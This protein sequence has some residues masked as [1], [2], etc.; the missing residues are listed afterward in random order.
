MATYRI[1]KKQTGK[2]YVR[3]YYWCNIQSKQVMLKR[4][5]YRHLDSCSE[6]VIKQFCDNLENRV[7]PNQ[8]NADIKIA[9]P[10][11]NDLLLQ[12][13]EQLL[14]DGTDQS[15]VDQYISELKNY[16]V[17]FFTNDIK[18][19]NVTH[20]GLIR[21][22]D[23]PT[24]SHLFTE[25]YMEFSGNSSGTCTRVKACITRFWNWL[26]FKRHIAPSSELMFGYKKREKKKGENQQIIKLPRPITPEEILDFVDSTTNLEA[27]F[28]ALAGYGA[29]LRPQ[30]IFVLKPK[31]FIP[32]EA[33]SHLEVNLRRESMNMY[34]RL[35]IDITLQLSRRGEKGA[36]TIGVTPL[37]NKEFAKRIIPYLEKTNPNERIMKWGVDWFNTI[38]NRHG[39][40]GITIQDLRRS[41]LHYLAHNTPYNQYHIDLQ[42][43][44]RHTNFKTTQI[45]I[46]TPW[47]TRKISSTY[48]AG[49]SV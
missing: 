2:K 23:W 5:Y 10:F 45:Y 3:I 32:P 1:R 22:E 7:K 19:G 38:W 27:K 25:W 41:S 48:S 11:L 29:S 46:K 12:Y 36:K 34:N 26:R 44:A 35:S 43:F 42:K 24:K 18:V 4:D 40:N 47:I 16:G 15:T 8:K 28:I 49:W 14:Q 13:K 9:V 31:M 30:E 39:I 17:P 33:A 21:I 20:C 37:L 6:E